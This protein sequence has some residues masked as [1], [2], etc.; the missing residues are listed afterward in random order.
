MNTP[1][2]D[3]IL[4]EIFQENKSV[5]ILLGGNNRIDLDLDSAFELADL[6]ILIANEGRFPN[7][8]Y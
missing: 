8:K 5:T 6:L 3:S 2:G 7:E 4:T 1:S